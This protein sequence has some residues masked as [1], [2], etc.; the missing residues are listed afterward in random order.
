[1]NRPTNM[2]NGYQH[3][4]LVVLVDGGKRVDV[5]Y[6]AYRPDVQNARGKAREYVRR[7]YPAGSVD[8]RV[9]EE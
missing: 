4:K 6:V 8:I 2:Y 7:Q 5:H 9:Y 3:Y 1:M